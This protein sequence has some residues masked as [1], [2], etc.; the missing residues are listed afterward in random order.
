MLIISKLYAI[1]YRLYW[2]HYNI[3]LQGNTIKWNDFC[4]NAKITLT[5]TNSGTTSINNYT[6]NINNLLTITNLKL[7]T[8]SSK[9]GYNTDIYVGTSTPGNVGITADII[10]KYNTQVDKFNN[11]VPLYHNATEVSDT[12]ISIPLLSTI[13]DEIN[14]AACTIS[15]EPIGVSYSAAFSSES[16]TNT[17]ICICTTANEITRNDVTNYWNAA[18]TGK[19]RFDTNSDNYLITRKSIY[20]EAFNVIFNTNPD[21]ILANLKYNMYY[22]NLVI[23]NVTIQYGLVKIQNERVSVDSVDAGTS[24]CAKS[25]SSKYTTTTD[26]LDGKIPITVAAQAAATI[27][28]GTTVKF[29]FDAQ[30]TLISVNIADSSGT[31][32][33]T[34]W[35]TGTF[36]VPPT[37]SKRTTY[38]DGNTSSG[39]SIS[40]A[41]L[42]YANIFKGQTTYNLNVADF[43]ISGS[44]A[45]SK[46]LLYDIIV[47]EQVAIASEVGNAGSGPYAVVN[48]DGIITKLDGFDRSLTNQNKFVT[49]PV[50]TLLRTS[51]TPN[52]EYNIVFIATNVN[53]YNDDSFLTG[54]VITFLSIDF[55]V[56]NIIS[57]A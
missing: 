25:V 47:T 50:I 7:K 19:T 3:T 14:T 57:S 55:L 8:T 56:F 39:V 43:S 35:Y 46:T 24:L 48:N 45:A 12:L 26:I 53:V 42:T 38:T 21:I 18:E 40:A 27:A 36:T 23:Y 9:T 52:L 33:S 44:A 15:F 54:S 17:K 4:K 34:S 5:N 28:A 10:S 22:Y 49:S 6:V 13:N 30:S 2:Y 41:G 32:L 29:T 11:N 16:S 20:L 1:I 51:Q 37:Y 31:T